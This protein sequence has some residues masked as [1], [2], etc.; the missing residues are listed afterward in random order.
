MTLQ[1]KI[2]GSTLHLSIAQLAQRSSCGALLVVFPKA[3]WRSITLKSC[4]FKA[5]FS[6]FMLRAHCCSSNTLVRYTQL[7]DLQGPH[8]HRDPPWAAS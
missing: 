3:R 2:A 8:L 6:C 1:R 5:S 4:S 7:Q